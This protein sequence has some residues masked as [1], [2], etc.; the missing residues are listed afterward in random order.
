M[1]G[2]PAAEILAASNE[3]GHFNDAELGAIESELRDH[4]QRVHPE[5]L[6]SADPDRGW[7]TSIGM[8]DDL[9]VETVKSRNEAALAEKVG[10]VRTARLLELL[11]CHSALGEKAAALYPNDESKDGKAPLPGS[12]PD[13]ATGGEDWK[14]DGLKK[15]EKQANKA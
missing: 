5:S 4:F 2:V 9:D 10:P 7:L 13:S 3:A 12:P 15:G 1:G 6:N 11:P 8:P 14:F